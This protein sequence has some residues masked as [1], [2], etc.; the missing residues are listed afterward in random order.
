MRT[1]LRNSVTGLYLQSP[2]AWTGQA[3]AALAFPK[4]GEAIGFARQSDLRGMELV[5]IS[6][7][8]GPLLRVPLESIGYACK[9]AAVAPSIGASIRPQL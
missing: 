8:A 5:F 2:G 1:L 9:T 7:S 4:M 6:D 3:E